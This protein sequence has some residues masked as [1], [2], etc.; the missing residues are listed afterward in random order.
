MMIVTVVQI[1]VILW[2]IVNRE[3]IHC[4]ITEAK[5]FILTT[6][7]IMVNVYI[8]VLETAGVNQSRITIREP[9]VFYMVH[10]RPLQI[11]GI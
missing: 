6:L 9:Y 7:S 10:F 4:K 8:T 1:R 11:I 5:P 3:E 2:N